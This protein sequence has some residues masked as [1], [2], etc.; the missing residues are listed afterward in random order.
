MQIP[1]R[2]HHETTYHPAQTNLLPL[3][4]Y[5][6]RY[7]VV[8]EEMYGFGRI[9]EQTA[10][11]EMEQYAVHGLVFVVVVPGKLEKQEQQKLL[12]PRVA[13]LIGRDDEA[14]CIAERPVPDPVGVFPDSFA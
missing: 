12:E 6:A 9:T 4:L 13:G 2:H 8:Q 3:P 7:V 1:H 10:Q 14:Q 11:L 5:L